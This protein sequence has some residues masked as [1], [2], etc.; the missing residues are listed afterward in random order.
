ME[1]KSRKR[2]LPS[3]DELVQQSKRKKGML[4][5][6]RDAYTRMKN[7]E[8]VD[9]SRHDVGMLSEDELACWLVAKLGFL[10]TIK[11]F[12][13]VN[14]VPESVTAKQRSEIVCQCCGISE[15]EYDELKSLLDAICEKNIDPG[16][17]VFEDPL[18]LAPPV[19]HCYDCDG[20]L[21]CNH[22]T[23][24]KCYTCTGA[25]QS[26][27]VTLRC[28]GCG[29]SYN[30]AQFGDKSGL[31]FRYYPTRRKYVEV[32]DTVYFHRQLLELQCSLA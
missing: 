28:K 22:I 25:R 15:S 1:K 27:K 4:S 29:I 20:H 23:T 32:S 8:F 26:T 6:V 24:V 21:T 19:H 16:V 3:V 5:G 14:M 12:S 17:A 13:A 30:Y 9:V 2:F 18:V 31:G 11:L 7:T 10:K